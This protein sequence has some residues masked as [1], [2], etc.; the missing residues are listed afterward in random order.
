[1]TAVSIISTTPSGATKNVV[2]NLAGT[3]LTL[4]YDLQDPNPP[5]LATQVN[6]FSLNFLDINGTKTS[7][8]DQVRFVVVTLTLRDLLTSGQ[9]VTERVRVALRNL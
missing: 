4:T 1:M 8:K 6:S 5:Q 3:N 9:A 7:A 2:I